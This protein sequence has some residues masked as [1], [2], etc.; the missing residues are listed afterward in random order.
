MK[1]KP[2]ADDLKWP[3][4]DLVA[5]YRNRLRDKDEV[6]Y[7]GSR[8]LNLALRE[9]LESQRPREPE[10][11][12][13]LDKMQLTYPFTKGVDLTNDGMGYGE[14]VIFTLSEECGERIPR[15]SRR[16]RTGAR[17]LPDGDSSEPG[18]PPGRDEA[19]TP[20]RGAD[21]ESHNETQAKSV[22]TAPAP[23]D[24]PSPRVSRLARNA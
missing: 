18:V 19:S 24:A 21:S 17:P 5:V 2:N 9:Q 6:A 16:T 22:V 8:I 3:I 11:P 14:M 15:R 23:T 7:L 1:V 20:E 10:P 13:P 4:S 12:E